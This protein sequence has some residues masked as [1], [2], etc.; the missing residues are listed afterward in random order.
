[1][2]STM[3][4]SVRTEDA[5]ATMPS[6]YRP[7]DSSKRSVSFNTDDPSIREISLN[8]D[9]SASS[10]DQYT[11]SVDSL[12]EPS[13]ASETTRSTRGDPDDA[14]IVDIGIMRFMCFARA[15]STKNGH[16][17]FRPTELEDEDEDEDEGGPVHI[18]DIYVRSPPISP[19]IGNSQEVA[20][21]AFNCT[22]SK[23]EEKPNTMVARLAT[24]D[25]PLERDLAQHQLRV[26][27]SGCDTDDDEEEDVVL[28][29]PP[30]YSKSKDSSKK[31]NDVRPPSTYTTQDV[32]TREFSIASTMTQSTDGE[33]ETS[34]MEVSS[35]ERSLE[36]LA[37]Y[38]CFSPSNQGVNDEEEAT[39]QPNLS[40]TI[41]KTVDS[42][43][44]MD[45]NIVPATCLQMT[46]APVIKPDSLY[47]FLCFSEAKQIFDL[48]STIGGEQQLECE[49][50]G[51]HVVTSSYAEVEM[52]T[53][54]GELVP[55]PAQPKLEMD[56]VGPSQRKETKQSDTQSFPNALKKREDIDDT[57][58][59]DMEDFEPTGPQE[60][61]RD[62]P[63]E[64]ELLVLH[65]PLTIDT[66]LK[67]SGILST[68]EH[69]LNRPPKVPAAKPEPIESPKQQLKK[70]LKEDR[71]KEYYRQ[72]RQ[73]FLE[74]HVRLNSSSEATSYDT[75]EQKHEANHPSFESEPFDCKTSPPEGTNTSSVSCHQRSM[76][77]LMEPPARPEEFKSVS[78]H[79]RTFQP[80]SVPPESKVSVAPTFHD[81]Y[82]KRKQ[83]G[84]SSTTSTNNASKNKNGAPGSRSGTAT[85]R[86]TDDPD[87]TITNRSNRL[88]FLRTVKDIKTNGSCSPPPGPP[89]PGPPP[90]TLY[91][92]ASCQ[93][94]GLTEIS[95]KND[96]FHRRM[97]ALQGLA[98]TFRG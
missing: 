53:D 27:A 16:G 86:G 71:S 96:D 17:Y 41:K 52:K 12:T 85:Q 78:C 74:S 15:P 9:D 60:L 75:D 44:A 2:T 95:V 67:T 63:P 3:K 73:M 88:Q 32:K 51:D 69:F 10:N 36:Q 84:A 92:S 20:K 40:S 43:N 58:E 59:I 87:R 56:F 47:S 37:S 49:D 81:L 30:L 6:Y 57:V 14:L 4:K 94:S 62:P 68:D 29:L 64:Q 11:S 33:T 21:S 13:K 22:T 66:I 19:T 28:N 23:T 70:Q 80:S 18:K 82:L 72:R 79:E 8:S 50:N 48:G 77:I 45:H 54:C 76:T 34:S 26:L 35:M 39:Q 90:Q 25:V 97:K 83:L 7:I 5:A 24:I 65:P 38:G 1:M 55:P 98:P 91:Y 46:D 31:K 89:S 61:Q 42:F 93:V